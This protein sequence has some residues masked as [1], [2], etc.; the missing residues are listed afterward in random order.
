[1]VTACHLKARLKNEMTPYEIAKHL[2]VLVGWALP[3]I[4]K[5]HRAPNSNLHCNPALDRLVV[6]ISIIKSR[7]ESF[8]VA[9]Q[10]LLGL[11]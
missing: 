10:C 2:K 5:R 1:M 8:S 7:M 6:G 9:Y 4:S 11:Y 3:T